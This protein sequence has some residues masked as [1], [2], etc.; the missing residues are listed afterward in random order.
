MSIDYIILG[1]RIRN[2]RQNSKL[3]QTI[4]SERANLSPDH[5]SHIENAHTKVS[6]PALLSIANALNV[7]VDKLLTDSTYQSK[8][9]LTD[10]VAEIF[11]DA[12]PDEMYIMLQSASSIKS[13]M[14]T[15]K[16]YEQ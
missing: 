10:E 5:I 2:E 16:L 15:R 8:E 7:S 12:T 6:L 9:Y 13:A 3:S 11:K 1:Q 14:R 4:L